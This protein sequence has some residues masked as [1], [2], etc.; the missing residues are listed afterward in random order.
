MAV[1][2]GKPS[3]GSVKTELRENAVGPPRNADAGNRHDRAVRSRSSRPSYFIVK[4]RRAG[5]AVGIPVRRESFSGLQA[6]SAAQLAKVFP[7]AGRLVHLD[8]PG[9]PIRARGS[10]PGCCSRFWLPAGGHADH[11][12]PG[13]GRCSSRRS[14]RS[15]GW[16]VPWWIWVVAGVALVIFFPP[17]RGISISEKAL[18]ITRA[19][20]DRD[21]G[22]RW[23]SPG[24]PS[25]G[26]GGFS[27]SGP[28][29]PG[30]FGLAGNLF[31]GVVFSIFAFSGWE[32]TGPPGPEESKNPKRNVPIRA[33]RL[34]RP[35]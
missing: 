23:R 16:N 19:D 8:R 6:L 4:F 5:D 3:T 27:A 30:N 18:I 9:S 32:S 10:S 17:T 12:V 13:Q 26:P 25:P 33:G 24:S 7:S 15:T 28:L 29:N 34:R 11:G 14:R 20:R 31:L 2:A 22:G 21:H 35:S 1:E